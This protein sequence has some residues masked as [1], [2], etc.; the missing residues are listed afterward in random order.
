MDFFPSEITSNEPAYYLWEK[1]ENR[2]A[3]RKKHSGLICMK[4][5]IN[6]N[7]HFNT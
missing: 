7:F 2:G 5:Q 4:K 6:A 1:E 3:V